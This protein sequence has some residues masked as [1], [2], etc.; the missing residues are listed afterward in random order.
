[1]TQN[2]QQSI[3]ELKEM[4]E[5]VLLAIPKEVTAREFYHY[6]SIKARGDKSREF[7]KSLADEERRHEKALRAMLKEL[8]R[9]LAAQSEPVEL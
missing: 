3:D 8:Q 9:L 1:M 7:F 2:N 4:I 5:V 6:A